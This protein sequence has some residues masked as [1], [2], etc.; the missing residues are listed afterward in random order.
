MQYFVVTY[1]LAFLSDIHCCIFDRLKM[2]LPAPKRKHNE[3]KIRQYQITQISFSDHMME[4][5]PDVNARS[6]ALQI[7]YQR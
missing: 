5:M 1:S 3:C 2:L 6:L 4:M 7:S